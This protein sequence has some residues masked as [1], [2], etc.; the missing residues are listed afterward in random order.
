M[1]KKNSL[2]QDLP[3]NQYIKQHTPHYIE[4]VFSDITNDLPK[5]VHAWT[6]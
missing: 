5:S 6:M 3:W 4:T 2:R 1:R